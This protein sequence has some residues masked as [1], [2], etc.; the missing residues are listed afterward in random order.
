RLS[1]GLIINNLARVKCVDV[2]RLGGNK[3]RATVDGPAV[4]AV[5]V[6]VLHSYNMNGYIMN[7]RFEM[8]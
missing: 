7:Y 8:T 2:N 4:R 5:A 3:L 1:A 6:V